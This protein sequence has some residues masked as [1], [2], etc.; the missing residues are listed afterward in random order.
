MGPDAQRHD[1]GAEGLDGRSSPLCLR[2]NVRQGL[3]PSQ[4]L[5]VR[6]HRLIPPLCEYLGVGYYRCDQ[7]RLPRRPLHPVHA[8][9]ELLEH[10]AHSPRLRP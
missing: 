1:L 4:L 8:H 5:A 7:Y 6:A 2:H 10:Y 9:F 3:D